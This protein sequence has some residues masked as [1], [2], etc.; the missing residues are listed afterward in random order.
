MVG[1]V[2]VSLFVTGGHSNG[3]EGQGEFNGHLRSYYRLGR[4]R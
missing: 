3:W 2:K 1:K 4:S